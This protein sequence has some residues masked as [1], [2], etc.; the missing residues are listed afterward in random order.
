MIADS[1]ALRTVAQPVSVGLSGV[2][3]ESVPTERGICLVRGREICHVLPNAVALQDNEPPVRELWSARDRELLQ[4]GVAVGERG[5]VIHGA[6]SGACPSDAL[7]QGVLGVPEIAAVVT[8][9]GEGTNRASES[10]SEGVARRV[11]GVEPVLA[12]LLSGA[13]VNDVLAA[14]QSGR[15]AVGCAG[16]DVLINVAAPGEW[17][18]G[19]QCPHGPTSQETKDGVQL[20]DT[21]QSLQPSL[22]VEQEVDELVAAASD[23]RDK[24][25][26]V[27]CRVGRRTPSLKESIGGAVHYLAASALEDSGRQTGV[28][29][30]C[31]PVLDRHTHHA[32]S[33][34]RPGHLRGIPPTVRSEVGVVESIAV[35]L[36]LQEECLRDLLAQ[37]RYVAEVLVQEESE[38]PSSNT[39]GHGFVGD[40]AVVHPVVDSPDLVYKRAEPLGGSCVHI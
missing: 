3:V 13:G 1:P 24:F 40:L 17:Q 25:I 20:T 35:G 34:R 4:R 38:R 15:N 14:A 39:G 33:A 16:A 12:D 8:A 31:E 37:L 7:F 2:Q 30:G 27:G 18:E 28:V 11:H 29:L 21:L 6:I 19:L 10:A 32:L 26:H 5:P 9:S 36:G 23:V 22:E